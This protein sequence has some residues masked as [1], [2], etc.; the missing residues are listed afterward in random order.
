MGHSD[1][2]IPLQSCP[3]CGP[4]LVIRHDHD[5]GDH[6][7]CRN[8][9]GEFELETQGGCLVANP[10]G[11]QGQAVDLEPESDTALIARTVRAAVEALPIA[12]L[13]KASAMPLSNG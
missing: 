11:K 12:D 9:G 5:E 2:G 1:D 8:C 6:I 3:M 4:T 13:V 7:Y 10:T